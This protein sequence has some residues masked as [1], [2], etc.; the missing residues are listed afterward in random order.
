MD[1][2][3]AYAD[4]K[5]RLKLPPQEF[6]LISTLCLKTLKILASKETLHV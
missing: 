3:P 4:Y 1:T 2:V 6:Q 5:V